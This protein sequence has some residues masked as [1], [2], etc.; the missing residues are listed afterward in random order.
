M[1]INHVSVRPGMIPPSKPKTRLFGPDCF[2][3]EGILDFSGGPAVVFH[4]GGRFGRASPRP[5]LA[6]PEPL[7]TPE[8]LPSMTHG[9]KDCLWSM[10]FFVGMC[11]C[12]LLVGFVCFFC[13]QEIC[14]V[15]DV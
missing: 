2:T 4:T 13:C 8:N 7:E 14:D 1:D 5:Y 3:S 15:V 6:T 9:M 12:F 10:D 11:V